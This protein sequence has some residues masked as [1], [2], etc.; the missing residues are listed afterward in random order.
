VNKLLSQDEVDALLTGL[1]TGEIETEE[2]PDEVEVNLVPFEWAEQG[3]DIKGNMPLLNVVYDR[4]CQRLKGALSGSI[5]KMF[6]I[7][8]GLMEMI[9]FNE[10]RQ[11]LPIPTSLHLFRMDPLRGT[12]LLIIESRLAFNL[13]ESFFGGK[14]SETI[15]IEG[16]NFTQIE[17]KIIG[18]VVQ[19]IMISLMESWE[20]VYPVK[21]DI[22]R[23]ESNPLV[24]TE[25]PPDENLILVKFEIEANKPLG[26]FSLCIP[27]S[28]LEPIRHKLAG[29]YQREE[30]APDKFWI[31]SLQNRIT[32]TEVEMTVELGSTCLTVKDLLNLREGDIIILRDGVKSTLLSRIEGVLKYEGYAGR[33]KL[34]NVFKIEQPILSQT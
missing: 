8:A 24:V 34:K 26:T 22:V 6:D 30:T 5:Q 7:S 29:G 10:F 33:H 15:R 9:K 12:G 18:K 11:S 17:T 16:R 4:L 14:G 13:I 31:N 21:T 27:Y 28:T 20:D 1:D 32:E 23:S 19:M 25:L 2:A 3:I